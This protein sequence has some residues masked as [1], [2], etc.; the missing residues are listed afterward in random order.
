[1]A[2]G[3][4]QLT[5]ELLWQDALFITVI[6]VLI[7]RIFLWR[8]NR[9]RF[10]QLRRPLVITAAIFWGGFAFILYDA[11]W[12]TYYHYFASGWLHNGGSIILGI[13]VGVVWTFIF[14]WAACRLPGKPLISFYLLI[15]LGS[16]LD[17]IWGF[18]GF[19]I[20]AI[21]LFRGVSPA[22]MLAFAFPE[23]IFYWCIVIL[24]TLLV[25][26]S[27]KWWQGIRARANK[28]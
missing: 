2:L 26:N 13:F 7:I 14:H 9:E 16:V 28:A 22:S 20:L 1:M 19:R 17:H 11:F 25:Q 18:Y 5:S 23:Y 10:R 21:P 3:N 27:Q 4:T 12:D 8:I 6:D 15:G 24:L